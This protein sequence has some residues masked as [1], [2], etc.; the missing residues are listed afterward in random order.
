MESIFQVIQSGEYTFKNQDFKNTL[1]EIKPSDLAYCDPPYIGRHVDYFDS[2]SEEE[3][4]ILKNGLASS[5]SNFILSTWLNNKYRVNRYVFDVWK[6]CFISTK[7]HFYHVGGKESNR[8][9]VYEAL[10]SNIELTDSVS[11]S[12]MKF[13]IELNEPQLINESKKYLD[14]KQL[15]L[16]VEK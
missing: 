10:L 6:E 7:K 9:A 11:N 16:T 8:N 14:S 1:Q 13:R 15:A 4:I 5:K 3:E 12:D 2:W